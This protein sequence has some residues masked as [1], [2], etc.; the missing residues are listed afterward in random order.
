MMIFCLFAYL[1]IYDAW[2]PEAV[3]CTWMKFIS[4]LQ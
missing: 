1:L 3:E 4:A 2:K